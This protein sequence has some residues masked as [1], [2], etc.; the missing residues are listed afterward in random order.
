MTVSGSD[1]GAGGVW[2]LLRLFQGGT[3]PQ[4]KAETRCIKSISESVKRGVR[5][6]SHHWIKHIWNT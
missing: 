3:P 5:V 4:A 6:S 1:S 2:H